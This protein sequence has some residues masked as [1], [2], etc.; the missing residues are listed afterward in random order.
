MAMPAWSAKVVASSIC[1]SVKGRTADRCRMMT[2][3][4]IPSRMRGTKQRADT[5][6]IAVG[7]RVLRISGDILDVNGLPLD[8]D[9]SRN[10]TPVR[11]NRMGPHMLA[12]LGRITV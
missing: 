6:L 7:Q 1:L 4:A 11:R 8:H 2:P 9:S 10:R 5:E 3:I 12:V